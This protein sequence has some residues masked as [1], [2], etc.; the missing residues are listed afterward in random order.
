MIFD[1]EFKKLAEEKGMTCSELARK[2]LDMTG[3]DDGYLSF[4]P[5]PYYI[6]ARLEA[7]TAKELLEQGVN[8]HDI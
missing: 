4:E 3:A 6:G 1:E 8:K 5:H 2:I 7:D